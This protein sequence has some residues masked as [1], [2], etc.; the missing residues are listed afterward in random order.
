[1]LMASY[2][3]QILHAKKKISISY[4]IR[5]KEERLHRSGVNSLQY[6]PV[7]DRLYSAGRDSII[8]I[9]DFNDSPNESSSRSRKSYANGY[10][11]SR[12]NHNNVAHDPYVQSMEHHTDWVNDINLCCNGKNLISVSNDT[13]IKVWNAHQG[14]CL[15]TLRSHKDYAKCLAH[16]KEREVVASAGFDRMIYL[17]DIQ[18]LTMLTATKNTITTKPLD[19]SKNSIYSLAINQTGTL[20][21]SGSTEKVIRLWDPR[22][23]QK[24]LK[25]RGHTDNVRSLVFSKDGSMLLSAS[26]DGTIRLWSI[27]QQRC[28]SIIRVHDGGV[29][30]LQTNESFSTVYSGGKDCKIFMTDL[31][32]T[33]NTTLVCRESAPILRM[34]LVNR[35]YLNNQVEDRSSESLWVATTD[36]AIK[37]WPLTPDSSDNWN[38]ETSST[39]EKGAS[40]SS[41]LSESPDLIIKGNPA[42]I[43]YHI[44]NDRRHILTLESDNSVALYDVLTARKEETLH[45]ASNDSDIKE[46]FDEEKK[47]RF[48]MVYVPNWFS[49]DLKIGLLCIHLE[50]SECLSA[51]VSARDYNFAPQFDGHDPKVNLGCLMLQALLEHWPPTYEGYDNDSKSL[52]HDAISDLGECSSGLQ[53]APKSNQ[54]NNRQRHPMNM[55]RTHKN[56]NVNSIGN[57]YFSMTSHTP[58]IISEGNQTIMRFLCNEAMN[59]NEDIFI[60]EIIPPWISDIVISK[61]QP[62]FTKLPF[63]LLPHPNSGI[64]SLRKERL[65]A[66]DMLQVRKVIEHVCEKMLV[67]LNDDNGSATLNQDS[68]FRGS[69]QSNEPKTYSADKVEIYCND[70]KLDEDLDLRTVRHYVWK[71]GGDLVLHYMLMK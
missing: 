1:M 61:C 59:E 47:K 25:L 8:R 38:G 49:V 37:N 46:K 68:T 15:S 69:N 19:G 63:F 35:S 10:D 40:L 29:W 2:Q 21:A 66:S 33:S 14:F 18:A 65:S 28:V 6:D 34:L 32:D 58:V 54:C 67:N 51:W 7:L 36:S 48:K 22:S 56:G 41:P 3:R 64:K 44:L 26:S 4:V 71:S 52:Q 53:Y 43:N 45:R 30:A 13:T 17:W 42:V 24:L 60:Q 57:Q 50:E 16:A 70:Q 12:Q 11:Y 62:K 55:N 23:R 31:K 20:V 27:P 9:W 5:E 39:D